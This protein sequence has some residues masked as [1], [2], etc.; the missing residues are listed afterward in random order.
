VRWKTKYLKCET[1]ESSSL[2]LSYTKSN[3]LK[4]SENG[5]LRIRFRPNEEAVWW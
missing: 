4:V 2:S 1:I 5:V 3:M